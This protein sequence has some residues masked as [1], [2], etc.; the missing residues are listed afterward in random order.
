MELIDFRLID[1]GRKLDKADEENLAACADSLKALEAYHFATEIY[2]YDHN[3]YSMFLV[4]LVG[5]LVQY[6]FL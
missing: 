3:Y 2:K 4:T 6:F 5:L 1:L